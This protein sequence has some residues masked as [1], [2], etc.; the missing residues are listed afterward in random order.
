MHFV[1]LF[2]TFRVFKLRYPRV[3]RIGKIVGW[4]WDERLWV[5][6]IFVEFRVKVKAGF[7]WL[8]TSYTDGLFL[9]PS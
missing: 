2:D 3:W 8:I 6:Y 5:K 4:T 9:T 7:N 1:N